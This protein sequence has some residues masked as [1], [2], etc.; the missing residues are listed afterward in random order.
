MWVH[1]CSNCWELL[2]RQTF[3]DNSYFLKHAWFLKRQQ[4]HEKRNNLL[5]LEIEIL[6]L[7]KKWRSL[8]LG[9]EILV[10]RKCWVEESL[11]YI[12]VLVLPSVF[13]FDFVK[14]A[15]DKIV[16]VHYC[17]NCWKLLSRPTFYRRFVLPKACLISKRQQ[18]HE[19]RNDL[20]ALERDI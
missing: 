15:S 12:Y 17:S 3:T 1:Y 6:H 5:A 16:W 11:S 19:K 8:I 14:L 9:I 4:F 20:L 7:Y 18:F 2:S 13:R 10:L